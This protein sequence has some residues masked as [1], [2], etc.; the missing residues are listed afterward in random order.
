MMS[1]RGAGVGRKTQTSV[2]RSSR[3]KG[4]DPEVSRMNPWPL[5]LT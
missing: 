5:L 3:I 4:R 2:D 1:P